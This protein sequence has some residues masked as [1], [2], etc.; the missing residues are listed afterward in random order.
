MSGQ[1]ECEPRTEESMDLYIDGNGNLVIK[2]SYNENLR[3]LQ[4][5]IDGVKARQNGLAPTSPLAR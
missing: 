3:K 2:N 5:K 4:V 1:Q